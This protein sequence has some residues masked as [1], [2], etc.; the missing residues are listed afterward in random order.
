VE[1]AGI[2]HN[3]DGAWMKQAVRNLTDAVD[4]FLLPAK[5]LIVDRDPLFTGEVRE[6]LAASGVRTVRLPSHS[7]NLNAFAE[8]FVG[9]IRRECLDRV[10]PLGVRHLRHIVTEYA[11]HYHFERPHQGLDNH[12][13]EPRNAANGRGPIQCRERLGGILRFY[14]REAA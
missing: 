12:L 4:G 8:R 14:H 7:P 11:R 5:Y 10:I 13:I 1:I 6:M 2:V 3:P 9:S